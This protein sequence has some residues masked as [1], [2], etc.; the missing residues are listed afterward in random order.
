MRQS[1]LSRSFTTE[2]EAVAYL[3]VVLHLLLVVF[4]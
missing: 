1:Y 4:R 3:P 2:I